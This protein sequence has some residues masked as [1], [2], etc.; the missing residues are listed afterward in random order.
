MKAESFDYVLVGSGVAGATV[1][2]RLLAR[3]PATRILILE[4]GDKVPAKDRRAWWDYVVLNRKPYEYAQDQAG[5]TASVGN[6]TWDFRENRVM[7]YGGSTVH[8]GGWCHRLKPEDFYLHNQTGA[9]AD[10][11][12]DYDELA[13]YY[14]EAEEYLAV[15]GDHAESWNEK[16]KHRPYPMPP[17]SWTTA[18]GEMIGAFKNLG[19]EP[20]KMPIARFRKCMATGTCKYCPLGARFTAQLVLEDLLRDKRHTGLEIRDR[21][22]VTQVLLTSKRKIAG[23]EYLDP[24]T[25]KKVPVR[26][27]IVVVCSGSYESPKLLLLSKSPAWP[28][29]I[30]NQHDLVGRFIVSHS[31]LVVEGEKQNN[32]EGWLQE[33]D[34]PTLMSRSYDAPEYQAGGKIFI[35]KNRAVPRFDFAK[36]MKAGNDRATIE[37][38]LRASRKMELQAFLEEKG[39]FENR[40]TLRAGK[41]RF[42]L[43][44]TTIDF[45][46]TPED[47]ADAH[48]RLDLMEKVILQMG[49]TVTPNGKRIDNPGGHHTTGT[50]R[51]AKKAKDGVTNEDLRVHGTDNLYIC[52]NAVF[53]TGSAVNPTLTLA[54]LAFRLGDHLL[55]RKP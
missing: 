54:A 34:F 25:G 12:F 20:G 14:D 10:W 55:A 29:G 13:D 48:A 22:P 5:E 39:R 27:K 9:G 4:A 38:K 37:Q 30:G 21:S 1:A 32:E 28:E 7:T 51:M 33:Y 40:I 49:Y 52:S 15:C 53:P 26:A 35:F 36:E 43:P 46:R 41:N 8:W 31:M 18:D 19:I 45:N 50:C 17:F 11:P 16:R 2:K 3:A 24:E 23:V 6:T 42:G 44:H 47:I